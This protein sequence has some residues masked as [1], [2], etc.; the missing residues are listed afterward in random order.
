MTTTNALNDGR[1]AFERQAWGIAYAQLS[2]Q[3]GE[4]PLVPE[5]LERLWTAAYLVGKDDESFGLGERCYH[6]WLRLGDEV[7][8]ARCAFW[9]AFGLLNRGET[10]RGGGWLARAHRLLDEGGHDCVERGYL[11]VPVAVQ[12]LYAGDGDSA[13]T[14]FEQVGKIGARFGDRDLVTL[15]QLGRGQALIML[16]KSQD[17]VALFDEA[18][19]AVTTNEVSVMV[20][21]IVYCG[22]IEACQEIFDLRRAHEWTAALSR[23]CLSQPDLVPYRGQCLVHRAEIMQLHGSWPDAMDEARRAHE[24]LSR[25]PGQP[26]IG[27]ALYSRPSCTGWV[28]SSRRPKRLIGRPINGDGSRSPASRC[29]GWLRAR[30]TRPRLGYAAPWTSHRKAPRA[31][32]CSPRT[33]RSRSRRAT[34]QAPG[35]PLTN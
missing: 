32:S 3:D 2:A 12:G 31:R 13:H 15:S 28:G 7:G 34:S 27:A 30:S 5:D 10:A 17:A 26:A 21:G 25:P 4:S 23:W 18:M 22:V 11:L 33:S 24:R 9:L 19:V 14:A 29:S 20:V 16:G 6:E 35:S 1:A 8:A